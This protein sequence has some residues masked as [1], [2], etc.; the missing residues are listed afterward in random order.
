MNNVHNMCA[1]LLKNKT[2]VMQYELYAVSELFYRLIFFL[3]L[4]IFI[5]NIYILLWQGQFWVPSNGYR[6]SYHGGK[7]TGAWSWPLTSIW[8]RG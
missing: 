2:Y 3:S 6:G 5:W 1:S 8:C 7:P 4:F